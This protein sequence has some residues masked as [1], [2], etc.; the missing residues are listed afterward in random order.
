M[1]IDR[2]EPLTPTGRMFVQPALNQ[3]INCVLGL[4]R[5]VDID[6]V[7]SV[8]SNSLIVKHPRFT[9]LLVNDKQG[10]ACWKQVELELDQHIMHL[11]DAVSANTDDET[12]VNEYL[13]DL[14]VSCPLSTDKPLWEVHI[15]GAH[16]CVVMRFH[17]ALGDGVSLLSLMLTM[18]RNV[19]DN[20]VPEIQPLFSSTSS[21]S[22]ESWL[23]KV[24]KMMLFTSV[25]MF[26]FLMR[27]LWVRDK[28]TVVRGG[29]GVELWPRKM[30]TAKFSLDDLKTAKSAVA[31]ATINDVVFGVIS[32]GLSRYLENHS[33]KPLKEGLRITGAAMVNLR[34]SLGLQEIEELMKKNSKSKWGNKFGMMLLPVYYHK[35]GSDPLQYLKR[36][37]TMIDK[38]KLS[39]EA[40]LVYKIA[41]FVA[42]ILGGKFASWLNYRIVCNTSFTFSNVVGPKEEFMIAGVPV[43]YIRTTSSSLPHGITMH[44]VSYAGRADMQILVAKDLIPHPEELAKCFEDALLEM[45]EAAILKTK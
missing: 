16:K 17:H 35:K 41:Y 33:T 2:G 29:S 43:T 7:Q 20:K 28:E 6:L 39:C 24:M 21:H 8:I 12:A 4:D 11:P 32:S 30:A 44:M 45:K 9:S 10:C 14:T 26:E 38:K 42:K 3:I 36:A 15:L 25:Y 27:S 22:N 19:S 31:N 34:P 18:G 5:S 13:A 37:K 23:W 40:F 1:S